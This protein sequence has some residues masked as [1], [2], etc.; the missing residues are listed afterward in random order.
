MARILNCNRGWNTFR[1][2]RKRILPPLT[3]TRKNASSYRS[4]V[5]QPR[6]TRQIPLLL[7]LRTHSHNYRRIVHTVIRSRCKTR[8]LTV[9]R[10]GREFT[11][12]TFF[13]S[14]PPPTIFKLH[15]QQKVQ[16]SSSIDYF[17]NP[18][19]ILHDLKNPIPKIIYNC[20]LLII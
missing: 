10:S 20:S 16:D 5:V 11:S 17:T 6:P 12:L 13:L 1:V 8:W 19:R 14:L 7:A 15:A 4:M 18:P 3:V 9:T 2:K